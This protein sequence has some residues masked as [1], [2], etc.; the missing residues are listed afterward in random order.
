M[1]RVF[2]KK[3]FSEKPVILAEHKQA[4]NSTHLSMDQKYT[5]TTQSH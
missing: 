2:E 1:I 4:C 3:V 5:D